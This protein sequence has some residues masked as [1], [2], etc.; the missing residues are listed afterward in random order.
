MLIRLFKRIYFGY[1]TK[2]Y[3]LSVDVKLSMVE[4]EI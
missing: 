4:K 3:V 2:W 1:S